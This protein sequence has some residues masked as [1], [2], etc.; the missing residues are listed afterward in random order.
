MT[1]TTRA[2]TLTVGDLADI[3]R[4]S[5]KTIRRWTEQ[6]LLPRPFKIGHTVRWW[7]D[8]IDAH[9]ERLAAERG[10]SD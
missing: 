1:S 8:A 9:L 4:V 10:Q 6:G 3:F 2:T 5:Q 7:S